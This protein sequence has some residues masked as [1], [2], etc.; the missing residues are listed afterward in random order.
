MAAPTE[1]TY[2]TTAEKSFLDQIAGSP[3][4]VPLLSNYLRAADKR[5][6][7]GSIDKT[8]VVEYARLLHGNAMAKND[9]MQRLAG[10]A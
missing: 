4:A 7:W 10:A 9:T 2:G 3:N 8:I 6:V 1:L 5:E